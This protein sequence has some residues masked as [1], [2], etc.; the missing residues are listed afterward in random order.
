LEMFLKNAD[1]RIAEREIELQVLIK[2]RDRV[3]EEMDKLVRL[4]ME[5]QI[6]KDG[7]SRY[8]NPLDEQNKQISA[9]IP[10]VQSDIDFLK[11]EHLNSDLLLSEAQNLFDRW[12]FFDTE[13]KRQIVEQITE[14][15]TLSKDEIN[16]KF[17]YT[18]LHYNP[19]ISK[20]EINIKFTKTPPQYNP[21]QNGHTTSGIHTGDQ[22][23]AGWI[24]NRKFCP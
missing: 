3:M 21:P 19:P 2:E 10:L 18:P 4:H 7:F 9:E 17:T 24:L 16:I 8:Y 6:P 12:P 11:I 23:K 15:I 5:N 13:E 14:R 22:H 1:K 20:D